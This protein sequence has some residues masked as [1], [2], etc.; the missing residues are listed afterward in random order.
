MM[1]VV[2]NGAGEANFDALDNS[3]VLN[4]CSQLSL[5]ELHLVNGNGRNSLSISVDDNKTVALSDR[6]D[7]ETDTVRIAI[8]PEVAI[9]E[10]QFISL[11]RES[12]P[13]AQADRLQSPRFTVEHVLVGSQV[14]HVVTEARSDTS[15]QLE[16]CQENG[17]G[18]TT[19]YM[20]INDEN[21]KNNLVGCYNLLIVVQ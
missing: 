7:R 20:D 19:V 13:V 14:T 10:V 11:E 21:N 4:L 3:R 12:P 18:K 16:P 9:V 8:G 15:V 5:R 6:L 17:T 1:R 2:F